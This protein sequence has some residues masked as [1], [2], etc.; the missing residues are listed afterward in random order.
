LIIAIFRSLSL[1]CVTSSDTDGGRVSLAM[2]RRRGAYVVQVFTTSLL[3]IAGLVGL[4]NMGLLLIYTLFTVACQAE[5]E[6][7]ARNE[8]D[9]LDFGRGAFGIAMAVVV[10]LA[11]L[12]I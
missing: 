3:C 6:T 1:R 7:P 5:L 2:F 4:D 8:V 11:L 12:P 9:E 10:A